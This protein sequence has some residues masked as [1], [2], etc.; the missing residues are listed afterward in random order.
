MRPCRDHDGLLLPAGAARDC[1]DARDAVSVQREGEEI[2]VRFRGDLPPK[3]ERAGP[4]DIGGDP[5][6]LVVCE[7]A[8][9]S[10]VE[11]VV[12]GCRLRQPGGG[13]SGPPWQGGG[14]ECLCKCQ[15]CS[16]DGE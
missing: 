14:I 15:L 2:I 11:S 8:A 1:T 9:F 3:G 13:S 7:R 5:A 4:D 10:G 6:F 12:A 16:G